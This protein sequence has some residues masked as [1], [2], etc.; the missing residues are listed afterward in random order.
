MHAQDVAISVNYGHLVELLPKDDHVGNLFCSF[1]ALVDDS[2]MTYIFELRFIGKGSIHD[3]SIEIDGRF[4]LTGV[5]G[6]VVE[7]KEVSFARS[8]VG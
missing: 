7:S 6:G 3:D 5:K 8:C 1:I 2:D 4:I